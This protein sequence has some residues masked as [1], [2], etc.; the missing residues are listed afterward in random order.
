LGAI[1]AVG[2]ANT[3]L[4]ADQSTEGTS[5]KL[6][7]VIVTGSRI[8]QPNLTNTSPVL[9][10]TALDIQTQGVTRIEDLVT[11]LP[12]AFAAQN[13]TV[14]NG[15]T[16]TATV[17]LRG[18]GD[19]RTLVLVDG[20]R[21]PYGGVTN[22]A[23]DLN[24]IPVSMVERVDVLT[25]GAS[26]VYGSDALAGV[27]NFVM[28][29]DFEGVQIDG[30]LGGYQHHNNY[31]GPG[32][33]TLRE[34]IAGRAAT[35]PSQFK[36][37]SSNVNDGASRQINLTLGVNAP[38]GKGNITAYVG[39]R[40]N[41]AVLQANRDYS[42]CTLSANVA[43]KHFR[44]GGSATSYPGYFYALDNNGLFGPVGDP[45]ALT[46]DS[47]TGNTFRPFNAGT[48]LYNFGP[49]NYY[50]RP[51]TQIT[52]G[53]FAHYELNTHAEVYSQLMFSDYRSVAQ[54]AP[55][56]DFFNTGTVNCANPLLS[57]QQAAAVGCSAADITNNTTV[58]MY[59]ARRNVEG[60]GRRQ[61]FHNAT[62]RGLVGV[63]GDIAHNWKYDVSYQ[64]ARVTADQI[65]ENY[66]V[67]DRI[68]RALTVVDVNGVPTCQ[69]VVDGTDP[70]CI[71]YNVFKIG[72][73]TPAALAYLQ[74]QGI[75][76]GIID[77]KIFSASVTG[78]LGDIGGRF[79]TSA[80]PIALS[81]GV[82]MRRDDL[83]NRVDAL[84]EAGAL[85]GAGGATIGITGATKAD[86]LFTEVRVPIAE[87]LPG[88][89]DLSL[90]AA[91]RYSDYGHSLTT[92][93]YKFGLEWAPIEDIRLRGS[94]QR[95][96]RAPNIV[97]LFTAQ[98][99][100]LFDMN[101]DPCGAA[102]R[103][104]LATDA[105]CIATG[106]PAA[107][108][109]T[110][111]LDSPAGQFNFLQ[112]GNI[113]LK[114]ETSTTTSFG[115]VLQPRF[116]PRLS[117]TADIFD[118]KIE[119]T[120]STIGSN[121]ILTA[122][123]DQNIASACALIHRDAAGTLWRAQTG[124]VTDTNIN[125]G[126]LRSKGI[127]LTLNYA[128]I[129][130]GKV[131]KLGISLDSTHMTSLWTDP[132][133]GV[134]AYDCVGYYSGVCSTSLAALTPSWRHHLRFSWITPVKGLDVSLTFRYISS[135]NMYNGDPTRIDYKLDAQSYLDLASGWTINEHLSV[136]AGINNLLDKS[137]PLSGVVGTKGNGNT[138]PQ[139]YDALGRYWFG[140]LT[141]KF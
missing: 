77:Q 104:P 21:M 122:C 125:I 61:D 90:D 26:A 132:G 57:A 119:N 101:G 29:K 118:I 37:P 84:Q 103:D 108:V 42:A 137:P 113:A 129:S 94:Y 98:G 123:Y 41:E 15:S 83:Q 53:A 112:G 40:T 120:I 107:N 13:S 106:V 138:F 97:E 86:D 31:G 54:I 51:D 64:F 5:D 76:T 22:S 60:G 96:V 19:T 124:F 72:G 4:A 24:Q 127:D 18:L 117:I 43:G 56:G 33:P 130:M 91:Y 8:A 63:H 30:Q 134:A 111:V 102:N 1:T 7:E 116:V 133:A 128:G 85:S 36:L 140:G 52:A 62:F 66:F 17:S 67:T 110:G 47:A 88:I 93:T 25:G 79:P 34:V 75:Q 49:L 69:S 141:Y 114:P 92:N 78:D 27:V 58:Q 10:V 14:S 65:T 3:S 81:F 71:P 23:A 139:V 45:V 32:S 136:R 89:H 39:V 38:D 82:E 73:V 74:A 55:G 12:Q 28:K 126:A 6:E 109:G 35:N 131:G 95:A 80:S 59:L 20:R 44:C 11:Q 135:V 87:K 100:N 50:Q 68:Q 105:K 48:D 46:V 115:I 9:Q 99:L 70:A 2:S 121:N 16:G